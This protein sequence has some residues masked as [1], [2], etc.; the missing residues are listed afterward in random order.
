[1][2]ALPSELRLL[3][4][5]FRP[6]PFGRQCQFCCGSGHSNGQREFTP[7]GADADLTR[8]A[9]KALSTLED[10]AQWTSFMLA[11]LTDIEPQAV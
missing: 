8:G 2:A 5:H 10:W 6:S 9:D 11:R 1:M 7:V 3:W 4:A